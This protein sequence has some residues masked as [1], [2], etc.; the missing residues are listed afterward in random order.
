VINNTRAGKRFY[1]DARAIVTIF[2]K[3]FFCT[4][5]TLEARRQKREKEAAL[6]RAIDQVVKTS[7]PVICS[8]RDC[9]LDLRSPVQNALDYIQRSIDA[10]PGPVELVPANWDRDRLLHALFV[11]AEEIRSLLTTNRRLQAFFTRHP[12][13]QTFALLT[14]T[15]KERI[16]F[17]TAIEGHIVRRDVAQTAVEFHDH[18]IIDPS[19]AVADTRR[20]LK[21]RTLNDL[22]TQVLKRLLGIRAL[23]DELREQQRLFSIQFKIQ[24]TRMQG[25]DALTS[26]DSE[27]KSAAPA[28]PRVLV[29]IERRLQDLGAEA[30]CP[31]E[32]LRQLTAVL[33]APQQVL[34]VTPI[35]LRLNWMGVKQG[36][37]AAEDEGAIRL[38][39]VEF[40]DHLKRVAVFVTIARQDCLNL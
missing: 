14:A 23:K 24:Q 13:H 12:A 35:G 36:D 5:K 7:A 27:R 37:A 6:I 16:I 39:E 33:N 15:K 32:Y 31:E 28:E 17:G 26:D 20:A 4:E 1:G 29:D 11:D 19:A 10:I 38:A 9:R 25:L 21:D 34:T 40:Q 2:K 22:V 8:L 3:V 30:D 18:R